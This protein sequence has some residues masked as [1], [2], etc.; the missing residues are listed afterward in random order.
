MNKKKLVMATL[1]AF[2]LS[3]S[4]ISTAIV[5]AQ[6][7]VQST[8]S[9]S[10]SD[11][12]EL[13]TGETVG[14]T[15]VT[16][17]ESTEPDLPEYAPSLTLVSSTWTGQ[18]DIVF[19]AQ[20]KGGN[21]FDREIY[22]YVGNESIGGIHVTPE[23]NLDSDGNGMIVVKNS[24]LQN[25]TMFGPNGEEEID[26][27][28]IDKI[29]V[30]IGFEMDGQYKWRII[31]VPVDFTINTEPDTPE[32][33]PTLTL[34]SSTWTGQSDIVLEAQ[35]KGGNAKLQEIYLYVGDESIGGIHVT[36]EVNLDS[37]GNGKIVF[38]NS[39]LQN[40]TMFGPNGEEEIDWSQIEQMEISFQFE[41]DGQYIS[42]LVFVPVNVSASEPTEITTI[43][44][45]SGVTMVL[46]E[47]AP[48]HLEL[49]VTVSSGAEE[50][51]A[52][53]KVIQVDGDKIKT[54]DLSLL[55][56]GQPYEY[57]GQFS[58]TVSIPVPEGWN[59][60]ALALYYFNESTKEVTPILF[61]IDR[62]NGTVVF[63][64]NHFSK[65]ILAQKD[66]AGEDE[67]KETAKETTQKEST[68]V[69]DTPKTGDSAN[70]GLYTALLIIS[71]LGIAAVAL[72]RKKI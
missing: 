50:K 5:H 28:R 56:N 32:Y 20:A 24:D 52:V 33:T 6:E 53:Q 64:T 15:V 23:V 66:V 51:A 42:K 18:S 16:E 34:V 59:L 14:E 11:E 3:L 2:T 36:P 48:D 57:N 40:T 19:E 68:K 37:D 30:D 47:G 60:D 1:L 8:N 29:E 21:Y 63:A 61:S 7:E 27:N 54:F 41:L 44:N 26:W 69:T 4:M 35:A 43:T 70:V 9:E 22:L 65:Y 72:L 67:T 71:A 58:S 13:M 25:A 55:F 17:N 31:Y 62:E 39:D 12:P 10:Q 38:K 46:P 45:E 49:K